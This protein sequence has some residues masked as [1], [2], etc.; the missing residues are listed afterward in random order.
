M[1]FLTRLG[2]RYELP[3]MLR[4][5]ITEGHRQLA[6]SRYEGTV[7]LINVSGASLAI[8]KRIVKSAGVGDRCF[9]EALE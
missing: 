1:W 5:H 7:I 8:P 9:W 4:D 3:D 2:Q 6:E